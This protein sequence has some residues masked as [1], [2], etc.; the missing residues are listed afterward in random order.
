MAWP[1]RLSSLLMPAARLRTICHQSWLSVAGRHFFAGDEPTAVL[2]WD[3]LLDPAN[4]DQ[5]D[6]DVQRR[7]GVG[8]VWLVQELHAQYSA[9]A[10]AER[11]PVLRRLV[12]EALRL[13]N[14]TRP[15]PDSDEMEVARK[16]GQKPSF[17]F[18]VKDFRHRAQKLN[19]FR[20]DN[21]GLLT[22]SRTYYLKHE[23]AELEA[24]LVRH[25][26]STLTGAGFRLVSVP[27]LLHS[28]YLEACGVPVHGDRTMVYSLDE[29]LHGDVCLSGTAEMALA[30][31]LAGRRLPPS[32]LPLRLAAVSRC[33]RPEV[34]N[35]EAES[36]LYRVH[37][38]TKVEMFGVCDGDLSASEALLQ[39][40]VDLQQR[41]FTALGLHIIIYDM[42]PHELGAAAYRKY[43][44][45]AWMPGRGLYGEVSSASNCT[46]YQSRRL[47][48]LDE[49]GR[50]L[51]TVNGTACA[52]P[53]TLLALLETHQRRDGSVAVPT[54]LR[55]LLGGLELLRPRPGRAQWS[56]PHRLRLSDQS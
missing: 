27:D 4:A 49:A 40:F 44:A 38:F 36:G 21:L 50:P 28:S 11:L 20:M 47:R 48:V 17:D 18:P 14:R 23:L 56:R 55:P 1:V 3:Y 30:S 15:S 13:P 31:L 19:M 29:R 41:I 46:D 6:A 51:H 8:N 52:V 10:A 22:G 33:F 39:E 53:R 37:Q 2:D 45:E 16:V 34:S 43:D 12:A 7:K 26:L 9:A 32:R 35:L 54:P 24:A 42:P 25:A 5:I